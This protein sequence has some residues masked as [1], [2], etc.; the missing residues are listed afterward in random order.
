MAR[1]EPDPTEPICN[2]DGTKHIPP[3][4]PQPDP[5]TG[6]SGESQS[7][8]IPIVV[9][10][11]N[12]TGN[13][14]SKGAVL[15]VDASTSQPVPKSTVLPAGLPPAAFPAA[16][17]EQQAPGHDDAAEVPLTY[18]RVELADALGLGVATVDRMD[19]AK[20]L[21]RPIW[22]SGRKV[23]LRET[24]TEWLR[25]GAMPR[26]QFEAQKRREGRP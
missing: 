8:P 13:V 11:K 17:P 5:A 7:Q 25:L 24:I 9:S 10:P 4:A 20:K 1:Q 26:E 12:T 21:P 22:L 19:S 2:Q 6:S 14:P 3:A 15:L 18:S 23:W 16:L